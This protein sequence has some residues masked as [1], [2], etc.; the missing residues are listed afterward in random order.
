[1]A[2]FYLYFAHAQKISS[3]KGVHMEWNSS[4]LPCILLVFLLLLYSHACRLFVLWMLYNNFSLLLKKWRILGEKKIAVLKLRFVSWNVLSEKLSWATSV[5]IASGVLYW[6]YLTGQKHQPKTLGKII[7]F[8][9][10]LLTGQFYV[11]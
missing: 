7:L 8:L 3:S 11:N 1:M 9:T 5:I 4:V 6:W 10:F 2:L